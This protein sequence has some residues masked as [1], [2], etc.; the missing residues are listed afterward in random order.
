MKKRVSKKRKILT[1]DTIGTV[2]QYG[3]I[4]VRETAVSK[5][6][7]GTVDISNKQYDKSSTV[8]LGWIESNTK[9]NVDDLPPGA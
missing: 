8:S 6:E 5:T 9:W 3:D 4:W 2:G 1:T 7:Y